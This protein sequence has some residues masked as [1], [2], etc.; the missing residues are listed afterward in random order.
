[1]S[2][3]KRIVLLALIPLCLL[4]LIVGGVFLNIRSSVNAQR[5]IFAI[6]Q[7]ASTGELAQI[8]RRLHVGPRLENWELRETHAA[9][10]SIVD[11]LSEQAQVD[12]V[13]VLDAKHA[14]D[15]YRMLSISKGLDKATPDKLNEIGNEL[16]DWLRSRENFSHHEHESLFLFFQLL[17]SES[18][19]ELAI[20]QLGKIEAAFPRQLLSPHEANEFEKTLSGFRR[21][22]ELIGQ[23]LQIGG[24]T[25][26][27]NAIE[28][29][30][31]RGKI[32]FVEF[33]STSCEPCIQGMP[34]LK[35]IYEKYHSRGLEFIGVPTDPYPGKLLAFLQEE[36]VQ[37]P[38][39]WGRSDNLTTM[40]SL[41]IIS[42]PS[43]ILV[44]QQGNILATDIRVNATDSRHDLE[45][46]LEKSL[47]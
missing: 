7:G 45:A 44:D 38:Q 17:L 36:G 33:W 16:A 5:E 39:I 9:Y 34:E 15:Y 25:L 3:A 40:R 22:L 6:P 37:W 19:K 46:W 27:G 21:R 30:D 41:G 32:V 2:K 31:Y 28:I 10:E 14:R 47:P 23:S 24:E 42:I 43:G 11:R 12:D 8:A 1:M 26:D 13:A 4:V 20:Q 35:R 18:E 29:Q